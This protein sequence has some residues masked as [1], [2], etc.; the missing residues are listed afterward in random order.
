MILKD[1][2]VFRITKLKSQRQRPVAIGLNRDCLLYIPLLYYFVEMPTEAWSTFAESRARNEL[3]EFSELDSIPE[4]ITE[5]PIMRNPARSLP[6]FDPEHDLESILHPVPDMILSGIHKL[7]PA[8]TR[9]A[10]NLSLLPHVGTVIRSPV[11]CALYGLF[12]P[13]LMTTQA[14]SRHCTSMI[15]LRSTQASPGH[16]SSDDGAV[17]CAI[18]HL[19]GSICTMRVNISIGKSGNTEYQSPSVVLNSDGACTSYEIMANQ[20]RE[21]SCSVFTR[22]HGAV[23]MPGMGHC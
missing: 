9:V 16:L 21:P 7:Q 18:L 23:H 4:L 17:I 22:T 13:L 14:M 3:I 15:P 2:K 5:F 6:E 11:G 10:H 1:I 19:K 12:N 20:S 8:S